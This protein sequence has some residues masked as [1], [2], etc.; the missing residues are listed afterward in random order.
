MLR[1]WLKSDSLRPLGKSWPREIVVPPNAE[2]ADP[3][4]PRVGWQAS[5]SRLVESSFLEALRPTLS[6]AE[7]AFLRSQGGPLASAPSVS[8]PMSRFARLEPQVL[9]V[10]FLRRLRLPLLLTA[11]GLPMWPSSRRPWPSQVGGVLLLGTLGCRGSLWRTRLRESVE[12]KVGGSEPTFTCGI[13]PWCCEPFDTRRLEVVVDGLPLFQGA[14]LAVDTTLVCP[15]TRE[16]VARRRKETRCPELVGGRRQGSFGCARGRG[17]GDDSPTKLP[18]SS[19][20][21]RQRKCVMCPGS[22]RDAPAQRCCVGLVSCWP[23]LQRVLSRSPFLTGTV[24]QG[25]MVPTPSVHEVLGDSRHF[26]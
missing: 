16:C 7:G 2:D 26:L 24:L 3:N 21:W 13:G 8:F 15:L 4:Q 17:W 10:L 20:D 6:D 22:C 12:R 11:R 18:R 23:V 5:A 14:Q 19:E 25:W 1:V 9:R